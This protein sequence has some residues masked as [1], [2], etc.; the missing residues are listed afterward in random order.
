MPGAAAG[1]IAA[2]ARAA[3]TPDRVNSACTAWSGDGPVPPLVAAGA[4]AA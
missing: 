1:D 2:A 4:R 3:A